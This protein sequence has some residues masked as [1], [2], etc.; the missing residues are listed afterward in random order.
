MSV[1]IVNQVA[2]LRSSREFP[3]E[4]KQLS[5]EVF[6]TYTDIANK[7]NARTIGLFSINRPSITGESWFLTRTKNRGPRQQT[8]RQVYEI[9]GTGNFPHGIVFGDIF[10]FTRIYGTFTNNTNWY[11]L[12]YVDVISATNQISI[13]VNP[14]NIVITAGAGAP[15][16]I[17]SGFVVLEWLA[18]P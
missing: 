5:V 15:P 9:N 18:E 16:T 12:P 1:N 14:T 7:V 13:I 4:I 11:P 10:G 8:F 3:S 17:V 6:K 2:Y